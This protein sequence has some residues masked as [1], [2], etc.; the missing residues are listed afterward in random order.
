MADETAT[1][2]ALGQAA[3]T[4]S[5]HSAQ[6]VHF[7]MKF[8]SATGKW[9][10]EQV[11]TPLVKTVYPG[12]RTKEG[13]T[14]DITTG[15][16]SEPTIQPLTTDIT[17]PTPEPEVTPTPTPTPTTG[18]GGYEGVKDQYQKPTG[19]AQVG[20]IKYEPEQVQ[21]FSP[22]LQDNMQF[23]VMPGGLNFRSAAQNFGLSESKGLVEDL[24][25]PKIK[26]EDEIKKDNQKAS[27]V[28]GMLGPLKGIVGAAKFL[29]PRSEKL[30]ITKMIEAGA[31]QVRDAN[32]NVLNNADAIKFLTED[33]DGKLKIKKG[34]DLIDSGFKVTQTK[35]LSKDYA[36]S[37]AFMNFQEDKAN[38][39]VTTQGIQLT[40]LNPVMGSSGTN[41]FGILGDKK[42]GAS[43]TNGEQV[44]VVG[45]GQGH[46]GGAY[47]SEGNFIGMNGQ[48]Y[49]F[50]TADQAMQSANGGLLPA[51][52]LERMT[53]KDGKLKDL[54]TDPN[55]DFY[56]ENNV[57][58]NGYYTGSVVE[59][60]RDIVDNGGNGIVVGTTA[61]EG[62]NDY[63]NHQD[64]QDKIQDDMADDVDDALTDIYGEYEEPETG[65]TYG[66]AGSGTQGG[67]TSDSGGSDNKSDDKKIICTEM[68]RQTQLEDWNRT[69]KLWYLFQQKHLSET[70][71]KGYHF[72]FQPFVNGMKQST[73]LTAIGKHLA[74]QRTKDIKHIMYGTK[75]SL[76][77]RLYRVIIEP[78]CYIVG[79]FVRG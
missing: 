59:E 66:P 10:Q 20:G 21:S 71:Q 58:E 49:T 43:H 75:F 55:S 33:K 17:T 40:N 18:L 14:K 74:E 65:T 2:T 36:N 42:V 73:V 44:L 11:M 32:G 23:N 5:K 27:A 4:A 37:P 79:L 28:G 46:S 68:Y 24:V 48:T 13:K 57:D 64:K 15:L 56:I 34:K 38:N 76:L 72:L 16:V 1:A 61:P 77:G 29:N 69:I 50:G 41:L 12:I 26:T 35:H 70:H 19:M 7:K 30:Q 31:L 25:N 54:Y 9:E 47:N 60:N 63:N 8:N 3:G 52:V 51:S 53:D 78:I 45:A 6:N 22:A 39:F 67:G 62:S